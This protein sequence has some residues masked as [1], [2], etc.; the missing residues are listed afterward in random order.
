MRNDAL[1]YNSI[2]TGAVA[3]RQP[4]ILFIQKYEREENYNESKI[5]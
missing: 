2:D 3:L 1:N 4:L 5:Y